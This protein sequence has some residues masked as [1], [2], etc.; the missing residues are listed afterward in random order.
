[1][2]EALKY[3]EIVKS[4]GQRKLQL[5]RVYRNMRQK[6][7][8]LAA[9]GKIAANK[10]ATTPGIDPEDTVDGM[11]LDRIDRI[12]KQ[13]EAGTYHWK[14]VRRTYMAKKNSSKKRPI[15]Q[16]SF[17]DKLVQE[18]IRMI[19][20]AYYEPQFSDLSHGFRP[21]RGC[22][23]ALK[24]VSKWTGTKWFIE[25]DVASCF[26]KIDHKTLLNIIQRSIPDRRF[27]KLLK[28]LLE[29]GYM[30]DWVY[31]KTYSGT[32]QGG[33]L[34]PLLSNIYLHELDVFVEEKLIPR[35]ISV[36]ELEVLPP[37]EIA[38]TRTTNRVIIIPITMKIAI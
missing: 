17:N 1:M 15:G 13:L 23:T 16:P 11:N 31:H 2:P 37:L 8:F 25:G 6:E 7:F 30:E 4:R 34:S 29:A 18:V 35:L 28:E 9:Y 10:G 21:G 38:K 20:E 12:I 19:L 36:S 3:I 24:E 33:V 27:L 32:P 14:P 5:E 26:D 22:H